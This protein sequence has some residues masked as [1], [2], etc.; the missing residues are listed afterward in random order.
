M[1][2]KWLNKVNNDDLIVFF[3]GW[4]MDE[5]VVSHLDFSN[6][7]VLMFYN[8]NSI[9]TDFDYTVFNK[10]QK[11]ILIAWSM[12]VM[13]ATLFD[14]NFDKK[15]AINGT[16]KPIDNRY[17]IPE[18]IYDLTVKNFSLESRNIF[19]YKMLNGINQMADINR[20]L[21]EQKSELAALRKYSANP[22][23][24]YDKVLISNEDN[25]IPTKNQI[26]FWGIEP[27]LKSGHAP[28]LLFKKWED[29]I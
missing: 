16:L 4:G 29:M 14:I 5:S 18:K 22:G 6:Y 2:Y 25:I 27:N 7:D 23:F 21:E 20:E 26:C 11:K 12:G 19:I 15:I 24:K 28:F 9:D 13:V 3:N 8:Y 1:K 17:G 10:Y